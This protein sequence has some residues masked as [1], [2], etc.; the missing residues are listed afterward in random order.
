[1]K[2]ALGGRN[3]AADGGGDLPAP[4]RFD[5]GL[6]RTADAGALAILVQVKQ[7]LVREGRPA[8][9]FG[10]RRDTQA[11]LDLL[12]DHPQRP[13]IHAPPP[14][15]GIL[16]N[17]GR[18]TAS[19]LGDVKEI[20]TYLGDMTDALF[21]AVARPASVNWRDVSRFMERAGAD[22][23]PIVFLISL[24]L[25]LVLA[26][27]AAITLRQYGANVYI[28]DMVS[29]SIT[30]ELGP[31]MVAI[32]VSG[33]SGAAFAAELGTMKVSEEVDA[34]TTLGLCPYRF[35]VFPRVIALLL[36]LPLLTL[37]GDLIA[38]VGGLVVAVF[39]LDLTPWTYIDRTREAIDLWDIFSGV[40]KSTVFA[41]AIGT[42]AC[43]RGLSTN[44]G[45]EGV[46]RS[47]TSAVVTCLFHIVLIDSAFTIVFHIFGV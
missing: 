38:I 11:L 36:V 20:L 16:D 25:G 21:K 40:L 5:L 30:R 3:G 28:A 42:I 39:G 12:D 29:L 31:L 13:E 9:F 14:K 32:I 44:G 24:L 6:V 15:V 35:L 1:V 22:G 8:A 46:G 37:L 41:I 27:Q 2:P 34:L 19:V 33:R 4:V 26:F 45:A 47:T 18:R 7:E 10:A 17:I 43:E 23:L